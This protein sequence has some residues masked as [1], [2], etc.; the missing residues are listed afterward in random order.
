MSSLPRPTGV[1]LLLLAHSWALTAGSKPSAGSITSVGAVE[2][3]QLPALTTLRQG[4]PAWR[5]ELLAYFDEATP[6]GYAEEVSNKV[7]LVKRCAYRP[8]SVAGFRARVLLA[9]A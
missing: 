3:A 5:A 7:K 6:N 2:R 8:P 1:A 9:C 4:R